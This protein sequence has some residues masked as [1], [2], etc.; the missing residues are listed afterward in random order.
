MDYLLAPDAISGKEGK[1][2]ASI[3]GRTRVCAEIKSFSAK[4]DKTKK[5]FKALNYRGTQHKSTGW[6]GTGAV[7]FYYV[8]SEWAKQV[9]KYAKT[10]QDEYFEMVV[11][12]E[13]PGSS[14]ERQEVLLMQCNLD[15]ADVAKLDVEADWLDATFNFTFSDIDIPTQF[16]PLA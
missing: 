15:G 3:S 6:V 11:I 1:V 12:N 16:T 2:I 7:T 13:D 14:S 10:G 4:I 5:E 9:V 8:T